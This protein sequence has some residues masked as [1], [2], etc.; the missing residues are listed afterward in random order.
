MNLYTGKQTQ[1]EANNPTVNNKIGKVKCTSGQRHGYM[2]FY[3]LWLTIIGGIIFLILSIGKKNHFLK[4]QLEVNNLASNIDVQLEKRSATLIKLLDAVKGHVKF[5]KETMTKITALRSQTNELSAVEK[6]NLIT[7]VA[8]TI[9]VNVENYPNLKANESIQRLMSESSF[10]E[11]EIAA[12]RRLYNEYATQF[13]VEI[14]LFPWC[15]LA[16]KMQLE[17]ISL[18]AA[19]E[20][21]K[22][23]IKIEF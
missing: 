21:A 13:N 23:D 1:S 4:L 22:Q 6:N 20:A 17:T 12:N 5:E 19:S 10:I 11:K 8:R 3:L 9:N 15:V 2:C 7:D 14:F 18:F 16:E